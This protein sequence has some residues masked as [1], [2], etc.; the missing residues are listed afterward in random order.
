MQARKSSKEIIY[1]CPNILIYAII[2]ER[3][4]TA[5]DW[6]SKNGCFLLMCRYTLIRDGLNVS[7]QFM[8]TNFM[9]LMIFLVYVFLEELKKSTCL[10]LVSWITVIVEWLL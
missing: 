2:N 6:K 7:K 5:G 10:F 8:L 4:V 9:F 3:W 1:S